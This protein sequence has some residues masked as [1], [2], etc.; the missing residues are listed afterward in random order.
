M[1]AV[2]RGRDTPVASKNAVVNEDRPDLTATN[3]HIPPTLEP[4]VRGCLWVEGVR[5]ES[6][7]TGDGLL[8]R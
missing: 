8:P 1:G 6:G 7:F 4:I 3:V 2:F 5:R